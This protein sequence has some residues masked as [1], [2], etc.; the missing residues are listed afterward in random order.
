MHSDR[1]AGSWAGATSSLKVESDKYPEK[2][3]ALRLRLCSSWVAVAASWFH[4]H[5]VHQPDAADPAVFGTVIVNWP[6]LKKE[7]KHKC[8]YNDVGYI[9][10]F[11]LFDNQG[12]LLVAHLVRKGRRSGTDTVSSMPRSS[13]RIC[14]NN[15]LDYWK[16]LF[17]TYLNLIKR[18]LLNLLF[19]LL[20]YTYIFHMYF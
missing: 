18:I 14:S 3:G 8:E 4:S 19:S 17:V 5:F 6:D 13:W 2:R 7:I 15:I 20:P 11:D 16:H 10:R 9:L 12:Y 1:G